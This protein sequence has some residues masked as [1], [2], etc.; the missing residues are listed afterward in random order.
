MT[1][2]HEP[3]A[4]PDGDLA[5]APPSRPPRPP[6][7]AASPGRG[8]WWVSPAG[9]IALVV[10]TTLLLALRTPQLDFRLFYRSPK[11]LTSAEAALFAAAALV[12]V[13]GSLLPL[14]VASS[15]WSRSWPSLSAAQLRVLLRASSV[16]FWLTVTGYVALLLAGVA[17]GARPADLVSAV[18]S[19]SNYTGNLKALFAPVTGITTLTQ[20][21]IAYVVVAGLLLSQRP[22]QGRT[23]QIRRRLLIVVL[24]GLLRSF[25]LTER[26]ALL[27]VLVPLIAVSAVRAR[28]RSRVAW[29]LPAAPALAVPLLI[30]VFGAFEY[31]RSWVYFRSRT[32]QNFPGFVV[33]RLAGYYATA[34][35]NGALQL[36]YGQRSG[37][38][39][40][41]S[42]EAFWTAPGVSQLHL[43]QR[44]TGSYG[45]QLL[46]TVL[47]QHG[48]PEFNNPGGLAV[49]LLELGTVGG[50]IFFAIAGLLIGCAY[51]SFRAGEPVG[52]LLYPVAFTGLL[53]LPRYVYWT[54]GRLTPAVVVLVVIGLRLRSAD[55]RARNPV[56]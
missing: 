45:S 11:T 43:Y 40:Y 12:L 10:P 24:L 8:V 21:G 14:T 27:E 9:A 48:N 2:V 49:P 55:R 41:D 37:R 20:V 44:V 25:F 35:N 53:E 30:V 19:Q 13:L 31:S 6:R 51:R 18:T 52:L 15:R 4:P 1:S 7:I 3:A 42:F 39:P 32:Q 47:T 5:L 34:Y 22:P 36:Q 29:T 28:Q 54:Q 56:P 17:R 16:C 38:L 46:D 26:L 50:L 23:R 33:N